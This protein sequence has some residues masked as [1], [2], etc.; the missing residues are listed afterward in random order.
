MSILRQTGRRH[1]T[2]RQPPDGGYRITPAVDDLVLTRPH[3]VADI[4]ELPPRAFSCLGTDI[5][6]CMNSRRAAGWATGS[7][8]YRDVPYFRPHSTIKASL[9]VQRASGVGRNSQ[10]RCGDGDEETPP[11]RRY[12]PAWCRAAGSN[13]EPAAC[14][15]HRSRRT[16]LFLIAMAR[17]RVLRSLPLSSQWE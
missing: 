14:N 12:A 1:G 6:H 11:R 15:Q 17:D 9:L 16:R 13:Y 3:T 5:R 4:E 2:S 10:R 8:R 7:R